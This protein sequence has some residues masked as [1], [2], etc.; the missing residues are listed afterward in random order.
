MGLGRIEV[1]LRFTSNI[2]FAAVVNI[3]AVHYSDFGNTQLDYNY[4]NFA[5]GYER[6]EMAFKQSIAL[7]K[8]TALRLDFSYNDNADIRY[9]EYSINFRQHF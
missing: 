5:N 6:S 8:N 4:S 1:N 9:K 7:S 2:G 3:G